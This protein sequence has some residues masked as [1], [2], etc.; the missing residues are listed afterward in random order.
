MAM[1]VG[2]LSSRKVL[3][4]HCVNS[5]RKCAYVLARVRSCRRTRL[6]SPVVSRTLLSIANG[7]SS[8]VFMADS[9]AA[10]ALTSMLRHSHGLCHGC[11]MAVPWLRHGCAICNGQV[12]CKTDVG[13]R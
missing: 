8:L 12:M 10:S 11:A 4:S 2:V 13:Q 9:C 1:I 6:W 7:C 5:A 3:K